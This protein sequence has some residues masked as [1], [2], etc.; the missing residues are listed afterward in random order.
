MI[1]SSSGPPEESIAVTTNG[2]GILVTSPVAREISSPIFRRYFRASTAPTTHSLS[3]SE[4]H[5][6]SIR[7]QG[8]VL[9]IPVLNSAPSLR[10][11]A[12]S[13]HVPMTETSEIQFP[14]SYCLP[15]TVNGS[16]SA[17]I[18]RIG[19]KAVM[20]LCQKTDLILGRS[21]SGR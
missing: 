1:A 11:T 4:N 7:H 8:L 6:P 21:D 12:W 15:L 2:E 17:R 20:L 19:A 3:L 14:D 9:G 18:S 5:R 13:A 16:A 10:A